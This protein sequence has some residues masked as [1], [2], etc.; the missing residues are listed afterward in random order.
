M[1]IATSFFIAIGLAMDAFA[2]SMT[3]GFSV[4]RIKLLYALK[5]AIFFGT[6]QAI[7]PLIGWVVG[8]TFRDYISNFDHWI[9]FALLVFI[10]LKMIYEGV[11]SDKCDNKICV[12]KLHVLFGLAVATSI[13][14]LAIGFSFSLLKESI[15]IPVI[16]IGVITLVLSFIGVYLGNKFGKL[17]GCKIE[18]IGGVILVAIG[19]KIVLEHMFFI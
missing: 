10:G 5:I 7:M 6:F 8:L 15:V 1:N 9:A 2:V 19:V 11:S 18:I 12:M 13:D 3:S 17:F 16:I 4:K 14:A